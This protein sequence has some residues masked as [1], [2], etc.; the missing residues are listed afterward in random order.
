VHKPFAGQL[1]K[2]INACGVVDVDMALN[3]A[4]QPVLTICLR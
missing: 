1:A 2:A 3:A 4:Q